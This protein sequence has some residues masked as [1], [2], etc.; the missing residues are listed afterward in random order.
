MLIK[1]LSRKTAS[2]KQ[3]CRYIDKERIAPSLCWNF[4]QTASVGEVAQAF[5]DNSK[6]QSKRV[7]NVLYHS[8]LSFHQKDDVSVSVLEAVALEFL[9]QSGLDRHLNYIGFHQEKHA[10]IHIMSSA[11][12]YG[13]SEN[14]RLSKSQLRTL[15]RGMEAYQKTHFKDLKHSL[16]YD[17]E[18]S[19]LERLGFAASK[20]QVARTH[21]DAEVQLAKRGVLATKERLIQK[22][23]AM[24]RSCDTA[25]G[26]TSV[27]DRDDSDELRLYHYRGKPH[28][29]WF[30]GK[31]YRLKS[32]LGTRDIGV[33]FKTLKVRGD[34]LLE[35]PSRSL[36]RELERES[37]H[38][39]NIK[40]YEFHLETSFG[41]G[42]CSLAL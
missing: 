21:S 12:V 17:K 7:K 27:L 2:F 3:L 14:F 24:A 29:L 15:Q 40:N 18:A 26:F 22:L 20:E 32:L 8:V 23:I 16:V 1:I 10:H 33:L 13:S 34:K 5:K 19:A 39:Q 6:L 36:D 4:P 25:D 37:D 28:G 35:S 41:R 11:N 38:I 31:K 9:R 30:E 42:R